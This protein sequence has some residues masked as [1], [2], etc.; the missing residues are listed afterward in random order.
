MRRRKG[1]C[2]SGP[3][4]CCVIF[5]LFYILLPC[6]N[7]YLLF[8]C[9]CLVD[10]VPESWYCVRRISCWFASYRVGTVITGKLQSK[11]RRKT[12]SNLHLRWTARLSGPPASAVCEERLSSK[13]KVRSESLCCAWKLWCERCDVPS[14]IFMCLPRSSSCISSWKQDLW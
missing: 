8:W 14:W 7:M 13:N 9:S 11:P 2:K 6:V 10:K 5:K 3:S 4:D 1:V 12:E